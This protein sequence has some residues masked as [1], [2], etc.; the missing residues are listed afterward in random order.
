MV[1]VKRNY[2]LVTNLVYEDNMNLMRT[3]NTKRSKI[4]FHIISIVET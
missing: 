2:C 1:G 3:L 4:S